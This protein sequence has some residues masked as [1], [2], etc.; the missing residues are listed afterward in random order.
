[1]DLHPPFLLFR[2][3]LFVVKSKTHWVSQIQDLYQCVV[4][5]LVD[6]K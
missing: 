2:M 4:L 1:M 5:N 6:Q 3:L